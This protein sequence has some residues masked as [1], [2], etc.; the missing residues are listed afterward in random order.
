MRDKIEV[1]EGTNKGEFFWRLRNRS[2]NRITAVGGEP[3]HN[4]SNARRAARAAGRSLVFASVETVTPSVLPGD[5]RR[6]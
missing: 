1:Y 2:N 5:Y 3:F 4:Q 6:A